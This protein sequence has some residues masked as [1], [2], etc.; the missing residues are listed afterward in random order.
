MIQVIHKKTHKRAAGLMTPFLSK[1]ILFCLLFSTLIILITGQASASNVSIYNTGWQPLLV[2]DT[3]TTWQFNALY[4]VTW[5][6]YWN[7][8]S[9]K[10]ESYKSGWPYRQSLNLAKGAGVY[11][12]VAT[13]KTI[14]MTM[15][16]SM[17]W[18]LREGYNLVGCC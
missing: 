6:S 15:N 18:T 1:T 14:N 17:N 7:A 3:M 9:Q 8:T 10:F 5:I 4:G 13:N 12:R 11:A 16:T 2:N